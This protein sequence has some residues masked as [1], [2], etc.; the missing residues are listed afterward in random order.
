MLLYRAPSLYLNVMMKMRIPTHSDEQA[1]VLLHPSQHAQ[2]THTRHDG[3]GDHQSVGGEDGPEAGDEGG[4]PGVH[5]H[6]DSKAN[7]ER[8]T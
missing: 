3:T 5:R 8:T 7:D 1:A 6:E 2:V 4:K